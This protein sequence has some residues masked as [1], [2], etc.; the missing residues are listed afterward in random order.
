MKAQKSSYIELYLMVKKQQASPV[1]DFWLASLSVHLFLLLLH[2]LFIEL[3]RDC[4]LYYT[5]WG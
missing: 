4:H 5:F 1:I 2:I 3:S